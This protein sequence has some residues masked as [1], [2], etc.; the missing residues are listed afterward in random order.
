MPVKKGNNHRQKHIPAY[1]GAKSML[2]N[3][4][5]VLEI[6]TKM[7][8]KTTEETIKQGQNRSIKA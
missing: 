3:I 6:W 2:F 5:Q 7:T 4:G 8:W 1:A